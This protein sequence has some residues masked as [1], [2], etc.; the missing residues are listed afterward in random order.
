[1]EFTKEN[2]AAMDITEHLARFAV[3]FDERFAEL[4]TPA[5]DVPDAL[6]EAV[7]YAALGPG[8]R[9][10]PYLVIRACELVGGEVSAA[11]PGAAAIE[12]VHAFSLVHDD[13]PAMDDDDIRRGRPTCHK[14]FDEA[15]AILAG[16][17]LVMLGFE[18]LARWAGTPRDTGRLVTELA[19]GAGWLGMIG[20]QVDDIQGQLKPASL[21]L[22]KSIHERKTARLFET[23]CRL[24]AIAGGGGDDAIDALGGYGRQLGCA[25]QIAD[26]LLDLTASE[27]KLGKRVGKDDKATKQTYPRCAGYDESR[28]A[29][30]EAVDGAVL[31]LEGFRDAAQDLRELAAF[32]VHRDF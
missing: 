29:A 12:C 30:Q 17:A 1:M 27:D 7:R 20:G 10:R 6:V 4:L 32:V 19:K 15:T 5:D 11:W 18:L 26:D 25:F 16:D 31:H 9:V 22:V 21:A 2:A 13:L 24:G 14:Q 28:V 23:A 8:K 3:T